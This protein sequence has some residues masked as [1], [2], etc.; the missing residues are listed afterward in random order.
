M[1]L[2]FTQGLFAKLVADNA[3]AE[4]RGTAFG[5]FNLVSGGALLIASVVAGSL[6]TA[7]G[8]PVAFLAGAAFAVLAMLGL[9]AYRDGPRA[10]GR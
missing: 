9:L 6:W 5:I 7:F 10:N 8:A 2:G 1:H 4:I 3:P